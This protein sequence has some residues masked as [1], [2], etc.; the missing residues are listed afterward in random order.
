MKKL[1]KKTDVTNANEVQDLIDTAI[2]KFGRVDVLYNNAGVM[3]INPLENRALEE[4][5]QVIDVNILGVL[6]RIAAVLPVMIKQKNGHIIAT[7]SVAD[8]VVVPNLVVYNGSK[9]AV[10]AIFEGLRREQHNNGIRSTIISPGSVA[11]ELY[12]SI[13]D[14]ESRQAEINFEKKIGLSADSVASSVE[15]AID[16]PQ[17]ADINEVIIRP[18][19]QDI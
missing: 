11:T 15:F 8:H 19:K 17:E 5:K 9:F 10:R 6:H 1:L 18:I 13:N 4:W 14:K 16:M 12:K 3:P 7:D 2:T